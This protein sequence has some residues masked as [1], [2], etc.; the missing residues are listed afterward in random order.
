MKPAVCEKKIAT[1]EGSYKDRENILSTY[2]QILYHIVFATKNRE[3]VL[4]KPRREELFRCMW[5]I[6]KNHN[7][8]LFRL[9]GVGDHVHILTSVHQ[10]VCVAE[11]VKAI[12][13]GSVKWI[14]ENKIFPQFDHWQEGYGAFTHSVRERDV[15][16]EYIKNQ[17]EH[18]RRVDFLDEYRKLLR[19]ADIEFDE[20]YLA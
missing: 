18:H 17:E 1:P 10:T 15:L 11:I 9:N 14:N 3:R 16:I 7:C 5:G 6:I 2:T 4:D 19:E 8:H 12:K 13:V 20:K